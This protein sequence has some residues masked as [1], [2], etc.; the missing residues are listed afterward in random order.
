M[1]LEMTIHPSPSSIGKIWYVICFFSRYSYNQCSLSRNLITSS[2]IIWLSCACI[3]SNSWRY[4][5][6]WFFWPSTKKK[7]AF[8]GT[9]FVTS[10]VRILQGYRVMFVNCTSLICKSASRYAGYD[11]SND[12]SCPCHSLI[13][14]A[15]KIVLYQIALPISTT[16][17]GL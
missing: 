12:I 4:C 17:V 16:Q 1:V 15:I 3:G 13:S 5:P 14:D 9:N 6:Y 8:F 7:P 10:L 2:I 11:T